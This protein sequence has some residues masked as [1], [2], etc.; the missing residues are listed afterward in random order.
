MDKRSETLRGIFKNVSDTGW[1]TI[2]KDSI[3]V[4][5]SFSRT[6]NKKNKKKQKET[7]PCY[8]FLYKKMCFVPSLAF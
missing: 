5:T 6:F 1:T 7:F 8:R 4:M 2:L 3:R